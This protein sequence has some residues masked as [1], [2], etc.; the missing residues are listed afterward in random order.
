MALLCWFSAFCAQ[1]QAL[2]K[3]KYPVWI[4]ADR[5]RPWRQQQ[6]QTNMIKAAKLYCPA[7]VYKEMILIIITTTN[8][9]I[10]RDKANVSSTSGKRRHGQ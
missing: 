5:G 7:G 2:H 4:I 1:Q 10:L 8:I 3:P 6:K 9:V